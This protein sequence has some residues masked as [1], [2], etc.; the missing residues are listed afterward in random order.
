MARYKANNVL[1]MLEEYSSDDLNSSNDSLSEIFHDS[2]GE[3]SFEEESDEEIDEQRDEQRDELNL[4]RNNERSEMTCLFYE[5]T[6]RKEAFELNPFHL[7]N[8]ASFQ[9]LLDEIFNSED[10][11]SKLY[12]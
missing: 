4:K 1:S 7:P 3:S 5:P 10:R 8:S 6:N 2:F 11:Q 9:L 12:S